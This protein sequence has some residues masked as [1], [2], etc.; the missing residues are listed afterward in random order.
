MLEGKKLPRLNMLQTGQGFVAVVV[1]LHRGSILCFSHRGST[2]ICRND[3]CRLIGGEVK[4]IDLKPWWEAFAAALCG[5]VV[6]GGVAYG[7]CLIPGVEEWLY[8][9]QTL[10]A[11]CI[12][13]VAS[14]MLFH[15]AVTSE[16]RRRESSVFVSRSFLSHSISEINVYLINSID[17]YIGYLQSMSKDGCNTY[18]AEKSAPKLDKWVYDDFRNLMGNADDD[19]S[20]LLKFLVADIQVISSR[21]RSMLSG[22]D[23]N[24]SAGNYDRFLMSCIYNAAF[25]LSIISRLFVYSRGN[26]ACDMSEVSLK[27]ISN[28]LMNANVNLSYPQY[29]TLNRYFCERSSRSFNPLER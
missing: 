28:S 6:G 24:A 26:S 20:T 7:V 5:L 21:N 15:T 29:E 25:S 22:G 4:I 18:I 10:V 12:A 1:L 14:L 11:A 9:W 27:E 13:F 19:I 23:R 8:R 3:F 17:L 16:K 2:M